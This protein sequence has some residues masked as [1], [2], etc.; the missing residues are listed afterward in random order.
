MEK[1][2]ASG[3]WEAALGELQ[4]Q[5]SKQNYQTWLRN[6]TGLNLERN[7]FT[8]G[9]PNTF[10]A[11]WLEKRFYSLIQ[12]TLI[13]ITKQGLEVRFQVHPISQG[14]A[15]AKTSPASSTTTLKGTHKLTPLGLNPR[16]TFEDF[17]VGECNRLAYAA[18]LGVAESPRAPYNP[19]F[20]YGGAGL[21]KTHLLHAIASVALASDRKVLYVSAE[22][23]TNEFISAIRTKSTEEFRNKYRG[24]DM[25][26]VDDIQFISGKEQT[27]EGFFHTFNDLHNAGHQISISCDRPPDSLPHLEDRLRSR[28][29]W[30]L[31]V[32]IQP[33]DLETRLAIL[34][35]KAGLQLSGTSRGVL[36]FIARRPQYNI[37]ELEGSLNRAIAYAR[38]KKTPLTPELA[39][40]ALEEIAPE[41]TSATEVKVVIESVGRH[42]GLTAEELKGKG[43]ALRVTLARQVA[44]YLAREET[45]CSL[46][47]IG[48]E[49]GGRD[50]STVLHGYRKV[51]SE[52]ESN[53]KFRRQVSR[54]K[55]MLRPG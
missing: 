3:I 17:V 34:Q 32:D 21:G 30:G 36:E 11:E 33:P 48:Q 50:H 45:N 47:S 44:M 6:T 38:I 40:Q 39:A 4:V 8:V 23:F 13:G 26:L 46:A 10:A 5:V 29:E 16:Y 2:T 22:Q 54:I 19:L 25:L 1:R 28:F 51:A 41:C 53:P 52:M 15:P 49:L 18:A 14:P 7:L 27:Q 55:A 37:R 12:K 35:A 9:V 42:F 43:K 20:I 24:V 31:I